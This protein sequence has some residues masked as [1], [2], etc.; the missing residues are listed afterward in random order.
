M[1][2]IDGHTFDNSKLLGGW[3][4][5]AG[6]RGFEFT[7][8]C[9][10]RS[11]VYALDIEDFTNDPLLSLAASHNSKFIFKQAALTNYKGSVE[12]YFYGN[13]TGNFI[14]GINGKPGS[15]ED[16][17]VKY[18]TIPTITLNDIYAEIGTDID[19][20]KLDIEGAEYMV[21]DK[22]FEPIPKQITVEFHEH[23]HAHLHNQYWEEIFERLCRDYHAS[24]YI[25]EWPQYK[26]M[27]CLFIRKDIA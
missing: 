8:Y 5:D 7:N 2:T 24:L 23:V 22:S 10:T 13:G 27:D 14:E 15:T 17:P 12:G 1:I 19:V 4:I 6:C 9:L 25:R 20:L 11:K 3:V 18:Q 21:L 16:R 26:F